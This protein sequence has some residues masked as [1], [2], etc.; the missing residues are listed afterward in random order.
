LAA[1]TQQSEQN[2]SQATV[3]GFFDGRKHSKTLY[4]GHVFSHGNLFGAALHI[5]RASKVTTFQPAA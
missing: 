5:E 1:V 2:P 4:E 3:D